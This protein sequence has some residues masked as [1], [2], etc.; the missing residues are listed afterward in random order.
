M[1][2]Q[3]SLKENLK[4][5]TLIE[6]L[7]ALGIFSVVILS[8][9]SSFWAGMKINK[10]AHQ[11][12]NIYRQIALGLEEMAHELEQAASYDFS[13]SQEDAGAFYGTAGEISFLLPTAEG[14]KHIRYYLEA[15]EETSIH[16]IIV[17]ESY[18]K[19]VS[20]T[21]TNQSSPSRYALIREENSFVDA[22]GDSF[23]SD[24]EVVTLGIA[25]EGLQFSYAFLKQEGDGVEIVWKDVWD[26][27]Y[28]PAGVKLKVSFLNAENKNG[29]QEIE[30][31]I[32]IPTG[33]WGED[34]V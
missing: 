34:E 8:L 22:M 7:I 20:F 17:G 10:R 29:F 23:S 16:R 32:Y 30:K 11:N 14:L 4:A 3:N 5:F 1:K 31:N 15:E 9:Y 12:D 2:I 19:N 21:L 28:I 25:E 6:I 24:P 26:E 27:N 33:F 13:Q 18:Q